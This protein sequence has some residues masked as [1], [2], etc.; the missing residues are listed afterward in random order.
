MQGPVQDCTTVGVFNSHAIFSRGH[1]LA[2]AQ[3]AF[4]MPS[5]T[6]VMYLYSELK[7]WK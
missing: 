5:M 7:E 1:Y 6:A 3:C 2:G 4:L